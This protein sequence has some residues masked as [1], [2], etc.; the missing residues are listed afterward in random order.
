MPIFSTTKKTSL[1]SDPPF[2]AAFLADIKK[3][4][5]GEEKK[6]TR[7]LNKFAKPNDKTPDPNDYDTK[8]P[9]FGDKDD[10]NAAE[11]ANY[12]DNLSLEN[13]LEK[14]LRDI[15]SALRRMEK[16]EYGICKYCKK[17]IDEARLL[18]RPTSSSCVACKKTLT[19]EV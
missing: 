14:V 13:T 3:V 15:S 10:E 6:L 4:L 11:V 7:E 1:K 5:E 12:S 2:S 18:A 9:N 8:F 19:Q 17:E 16:E